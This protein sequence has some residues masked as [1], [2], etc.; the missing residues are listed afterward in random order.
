MEPDPKKLR[1]ALKFKGSAQLKS[2]SH[3]IVAGGLL[4]IS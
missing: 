3:S 4:V 2:Y 1:G